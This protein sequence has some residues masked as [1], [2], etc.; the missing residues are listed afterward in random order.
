LGLLRGCSRGL[1]QNRIPELGPNVAGLSILLYIDNQPYLAV[2]SVTG[3]PCSAI[4]RGQADQPGGRD[5]R[6]ALCAQ[7]RHRRYKRQHGGGTDSTHGSMVSRAQMGWTM[8]FFAFGFRW[9]SG[10]W[11]NE[12]HCKELT[13]G[14]LRMTFPDCVP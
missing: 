6:L 4:R 3:L 14:L 12:E 8:I 7:G 2:T 13:N 1:D 9:I 10:S 5:G 11:Q